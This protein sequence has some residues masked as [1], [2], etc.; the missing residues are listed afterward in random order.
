MGTRSTVV[1]LN[2][3]T[4]CT[5]TRENR[6]LSHGIWTSRPPAR[7]YDQQQGSRASGSSGFATGTEGIARFF[8]ENRA[9]P[10][11]NG[12]IIQVHR[13]NPYLGSHS[14]DSTGTDLMF[15]V[16]QPAGGSGNQ[17]TAEFSAW[18]RRPLSQG[19]GKGATGAV[20]GVG[21]ARVGRYGRSLIKP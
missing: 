12:R 5:L 1:R 17:A 15:Y 19:D 13:D 18:R 7:I 2:N 20:R 6:S 14:Y 11:L 10:V 21:G 9:S 4:G 3:W 8:A 16:P